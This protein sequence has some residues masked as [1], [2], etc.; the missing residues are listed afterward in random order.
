MLSILILE[1]YF[2]ETCSLLSS[3]SCLHTEKQQREY[4]GCIH[5]MR[6]N[7]MKRT[8]NGRDGSDNN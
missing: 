1:K 6:D 3:Y 8:R 4:R 2:H 7:E 5:D